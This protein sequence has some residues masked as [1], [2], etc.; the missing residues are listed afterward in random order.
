MMNVNG[1]GENSAS[2]ML[3]PGVALAVDQEKR[4]ASSYGFMKGT[5]QFQRW[6]ASKTWR[7]C[8][9]SIDSIPPI[10][11]ICENHL[12]PDRA[13]KKTFLWRK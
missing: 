10:D 11:F 1:V 5:R 13:A 4:I 6:A 12:F 3:W 8:I 2:S 7:R 9:R